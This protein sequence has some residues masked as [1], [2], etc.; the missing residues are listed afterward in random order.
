M[1]TSV[2]SVPCQMSAASTL[3]LLLLAALAVSTASAGNWYDGIAGVKVLHPGQPD[4]QQI[5]DAVA[6]SQLSDDSGQFDPLRFA[7]LLT[8]GD[9]GNLSINTGFYT[10]VAGVGT[11]PASV[12]L[13]NVQSF[14]GTVGGA[15]QNFWR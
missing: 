9:H 5:V 11:G 14:D 3:G 2:T 15:T 8:P 7:I 6:K 10:S 1:G 13:A 4:A 12:T